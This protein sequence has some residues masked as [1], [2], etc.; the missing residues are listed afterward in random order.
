MRVALFIELEGGLVDDVT[1]FLD[2]AK[3]RQAHHDWCVK[4]DALPFGDPSDE[5]LYATV[6]TVEVTE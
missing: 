4:N 6:F 1:A 2:P 5:D 3:A